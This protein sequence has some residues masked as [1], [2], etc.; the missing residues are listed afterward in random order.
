MG[1]ATLPLV[2]PYELLLQQVEHMQTLAAAGYWVA[3][4]QEASAY[5]INVEALKRAEA[6]LPQDEVS[7]SRRREL[8]ER[9]LAIDVEIRSKLSTRRDELSELLEQSSQPRNTGRTI[10]TGKNSSSV[11]AMYQAFERF[12]KS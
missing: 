8:L 6:Y 12:G 3:L 4:I 10:N 7:K 9:I 11:A 1:G 5:V 2:E